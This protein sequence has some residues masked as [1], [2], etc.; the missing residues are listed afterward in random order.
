[1]VIEWETEEGFAE[2]DKEDGKHTCSI[3]PE[4]SH[5][6]IYGIFS[7]D[8]IEQILSKMKE[9]CIEDQQKTLQ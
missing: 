5:L 2:F 4:G 3:L 7:I 9:L 8:E 6:Q 1:M